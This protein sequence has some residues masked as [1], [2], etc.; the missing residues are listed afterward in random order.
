[1]TFDVEYYS[2][3]SSDIARLAFR[4]ALLNKVY[5]ETS[6]MAR[7]VAALYLTE[8]NTG[9]LAALEV[10]P[11]ASPS[12]ILGL[13]L[14]LRKCE[15]C[16]QYEGASL[17]PRAAKSDM[18]PCEQTVNVCGP[19]PCTGGTIC[20]LDGGANGGYR[21][22]CTVGNACD[23]IARQGESGGASGSDS[24]ASIANEV[25]VLVVGCVVV[26]LL[27]VVAV[28]L[29]RQQRIMHAAQNEY[30][31]S[32]DSSSDGNTF[33]TQRTDAMTEDSEWDE[34][35]QEHM[36]AILLAK[37]N[38]GMPFVAPFIAPFK[39]FS[40]EPEY[41]ALGDSATRLTGNHGTDGAN[42]SLRSVN[43]FAMMFSGDANDSVKS[44]NELYVFIPGSL[45]VLLFP[46]MLTRCRPL[47]FINSGERA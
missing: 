16:V 29:V 4:E 8:R 17:C 12:A 31:R 13:E 42:D 43:S 46:S 32:H 37:K 28:L 39:E 47:L 9:V 23:S 35:W 26:V 45:F 10:A 7:D 5:L 34:A 1:M 38:T 19:K 21:C 14:S 20:V 41:E 6:L 36:A 3:L 44:F 40:P 25:S 18:K 11:D 2:I 15:F 30:P 24:G 33:I 22:V 27:G